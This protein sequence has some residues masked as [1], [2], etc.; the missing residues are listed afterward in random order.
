MKIKNNKFTYCDAADDGGTHKIAI[1]VTLYFDISAIQQQLSALV[2]TALD[3]TTHS[4]L[5]L[6]GDQRPNIGT[7]LVS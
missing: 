7:R 3:Q 6:G 4:L 2:H 1:L 5:G